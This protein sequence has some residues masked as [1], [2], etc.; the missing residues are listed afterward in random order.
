MV[1]LSSLGS[2]SADSAT[3]RI[4]VAIDVKLLEYMQHCTKRRQV[5]GQLSWIVGK[6]YTPSFF[7]RMVMY[8]R[9][10]NAETRRSSEAVR[11]V[12]TQTGKLKSVP[13]WIMTS[14]LWCHVIHGVVLTGSANP[15]NTQLSGSD[16]SEANRTAKF[17]ACRTAVGNCGE[18]V[19]EPLGYLSDA[20]TPFL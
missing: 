8:K 13:T 11:R 4:S 3:F 1:P 9:I 2:V 10:H 15:A 19:I 17:T 14:H 20:K 6:M 7:L 5:D 12:R 18:D 16:T